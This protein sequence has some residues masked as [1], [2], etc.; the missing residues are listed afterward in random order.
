MSADAVVV[1]EL[2]EDFR[3]EDR[4]LWASCQATAAQVADLINERLDEARAYLEELEEQPP[5]RDHDTSADRFNLVYNFTSVLD[6][7]RDA[8][9]ALRRA[10]R[11]APRRPH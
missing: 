9:R 2:R 10:R 3:E 7:L 4:R 5:A 1:N 6:E 11:L 8:E